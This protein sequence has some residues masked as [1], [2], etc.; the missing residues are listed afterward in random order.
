MKTSIYPTSYRQLRTTLANLG[1][2]AETLEKEMAKLPKYSNFW[3]GKLKGLD[4]VVSEIL[5]LKTHWTPPGPICRPRKLN[6][7][8]DAEY[9]AEVYRFEPYKG[10]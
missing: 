5:F 4:E 1:F 2:L 6:E 7:L 3:W 10:I 8:E 9:E